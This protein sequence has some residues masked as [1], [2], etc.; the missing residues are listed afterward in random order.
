MEKEI[1]NVKNSANGDNLRLSEF[2]TPVFKGKR[3]DLHTIPLG[4]LKDIGAIQEII[5]AI[6]K[7]LYKNKNGN[8]KRLPNNFKKNLEIHL[9]EVNKGSAK[10]KLSF[11]N[12]DGEMF[13]PAYHALYEEAY[14]IF[15]NEIDAANDDNFHSI[16]RDIYYY[17]DNIGR[18]LEEGEY[19]E[20]PRLQVKS[21]KN[22]YYNNEIR[23]KLR[24]K[25]DK[26]YTED[27]YLRGRIVI[28]NQLKSEF[29]IK[30]EN[31]K[32]EIIDCSF[33]SSIRQ[34]VVE[35]VKDY[36]NAVYKIYGTATININGD[37]EKISDV[38]E[39]EVVPID[40]VPTK[41]FKY[42]CYK[43]GWF[44]GEGIPINKK[45]ATLFC[46]Y[47]DKY[48]SDYVSSPVVYFN[49]DGCIELEWDFDS[50]AVSCSVDLESFKA[51]FLIS[52]FENAGVMGLHEFYLNNKD[53]FDGLNNK[54]L[55]YYQ[56]D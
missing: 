15:L 7:N 46:N 43:K 48:Y 41:I 39:M 3:F 30:L 2:F 35:A 18:G 26:K 32:S 53:G 24:I 27:L 16:N 52:S 1:A 14:E 21:D 49:T 34:T 17:F 5:F 19:I 23:K 55:E 50:I 36:E 28:I 20:F 47:W 45:N 42:F 33:S 22:S 56:G 54:L 40:D 38:E 29:G 25:A 13:P 37:V 11:I 51:E 8:N 31:I 12:Q 6:A 4:V 10:P 44:D 9:T